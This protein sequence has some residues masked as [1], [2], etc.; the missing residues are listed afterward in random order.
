MGSTTLP[1]LISEGLYERKE[2]ISTDAVALVAEMVL[3]WLRGAVERMAK[4][5]KDA[6]LF[7][8]FIRPWVPMDINA[9]MHMAM[10]HNAK[11]GILGSYRRGFLGVAVI[12]EWWEPGLYY[13][14]GPGRWGE[15]VAYIRFTPIAESD[16]SP[17]LRV[18]ARS[19]PDSISILDIHQVPAAGGDSWDIKRVVKARPFRD[20]Q[21]LA[22]DN[23]SL[24]GSNHDGE[25]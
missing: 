8:F 19:D 10:G 22:M 12:K 9:A 20:A 2:S 11:R 17:V 5:G 25:N 7:R 23:D 24:T 1:V 4:E 18:L 6:R 14:E 3:A 13:R 21:A 16:L 15:D